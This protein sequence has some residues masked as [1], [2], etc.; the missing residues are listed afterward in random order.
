MLINKGLERATGELI[1]W[2]NSDDRSLRAH[3]SMWPMYTIQQMRLLFVDR[4]QCFAIIRNGSI[5][6]RIVQEY[7]EICFGR[8]SYNQPGTYFHSSAVQKMGVPD[9]RLHYVMDKEWFIRYLLL[10]GIERIAVTEQS[11]ALYRFMIRQKP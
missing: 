4:L 8:D 9:E 11:L 6:R 7:V 5:R 3:C 2:I 1:N 10:F